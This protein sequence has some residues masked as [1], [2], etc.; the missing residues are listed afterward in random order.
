VL[1]KIGS[2]PQKIAD[3]AGHY[4]KS[5][6]WNETNAAKAGTIR[7]GTA[8][9]TDPKEWILSGPHIFVANPYSQTPRAYCGM[10]LH[11]DSPDLTE[12][13]ENY[14]P[15]GNFFPA[16][17]PDTYHGRIPR[18]PWD[19]KNPVTDFYRVINR[20]RL[21]ESTERTLL[22]AIIPPGPAHI[23]ACF[24]LILQSTDAMI[25]VAGAC[26]SV[27]LD[28]FVKATGKSDLRDDLARR[29][30]L[31]ASLPELAVRTLRLNCLTRFYRVLWE[32]SWMSNFKA[33]QWTKDDPRLSTE[34]F[35]K[36]SP[37]WSLQT[38]VRTDYERRQALVEIDVLVAMELG[39]TLAELCTI[40]RIQFSV[41][42]QYER[43]TYFDRN[44]R[45]VY[46]DGEKAYGLSAP[47]W[48]RKCHLDRI[49]RTV[50]DATLLG[51]P[52]ERTIVYEAPFDQCDREEDYK[53]AWAEFER[54]RA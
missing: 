35:R 36:L 45:I 30:P 43:N 15:R 44:G 10:G 4:S 21:D 22:S 9:S 29:L 27:P 7:P 20:R 16:C 8:F 11:Y 50:T 2:Y 31:L 25:R 17:D 52:R 23:D 18:V 14:L 38:P 47:E 37:E 54:R 1:A 34:S 24:S 19:S 46:L 48:K 39:I 53:T 3:L 6:M 51:D 5:E 26:A 13:P 42:R 28:F 32:E 41:L 12:L 40:Y 33:D 49:E